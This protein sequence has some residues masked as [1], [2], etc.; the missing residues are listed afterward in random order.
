M[1]S[2]GYVGPAEI[3]ARAVE[4]NGGT[5]A[6]SQEAV[7]TWLRDNFTPDAGWATFVVDLSGTLLVAPRRTEHVACAAGNRVLAAGELRFARDGAVAEITNNSTG[8]CPAEDCWPAVD[9]ALKRAGLVG[10]SSFTF[11]ARF[12]RCP[13]CLE[14]NLIKDDWYYCAFCDSALPLAWNFDERI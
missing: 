7:L 10:P 3:R 9:A 11:V 12:R 13:R 1:R 14:R 6:D 2:F 4:G 5:P 8:Y